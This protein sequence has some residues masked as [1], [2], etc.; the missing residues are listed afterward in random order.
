MSWGARVCLVALGLAAVLGGGCA[1]K[2]LLQARPYRLLVPVHVDPRT[3][4][5]LLVALHGYGANAEM[6][7]DYLDDYL[8]LQ[9]VA[10]ERRF[11]VALPDGTFERGGAEPRRFWNATDACCNFAGSTV[12]DVAY[13]EAVID[14][15]AARQRVDARRVFVIGH[16]NGGFMAHRLA[17]ESSRIAAIVSLAGAVW[18]EPARCRPPAPV[19]V[20]QVHG[21]ADSIIH[22]DGGQFL[23][24]A[25]YP[26]A[27]ET[28]A[29]WA[30]KNG[31]APGRVDGAIA[32]DL[33]DDLAG[34][35][36]RVERSCGGAVELW[37]IHGGSHVPRLSAAFSTAVY[38]FLSAHPRR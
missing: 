35:E 21:D 6:L 30:A 2:K 5:P 25:P 27:R 14:D 31:C 19:A 22:Y 24:G 29:I 12:D 36:T 20:L 26:S 18:R 17:C 7:E 16:S 1:R 34:A 4:L 37:T 13:L 33:D 3:P 38:D 11:F 10:D 15:V 9:R 28:I 8:D 32:L 23:T